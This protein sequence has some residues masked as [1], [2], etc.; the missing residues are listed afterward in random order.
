[1]KINWS[2]VILGALLMALGFLYIK[3]CKNSASYLKV[4]QDSLNIHK[5]I[6]QKVIDDTLKLKKA[7]DSL[8]E[9]NILDNNRYTKKIDSLSKII[10]KTNERFQIT[11]D[12]IG[13]L[14][15]QL[16]TFYLNNDTDALKNTY[17]ELKQKLDEANNQLF[18]L[19]ND[20][21][22]VDFEKDS[23]ILRQR[24]VIETLKSQLDSA[25]KLLG[26]QISN[27]KAEEA[28]IQ[29]LIDKNK[30]ARFIKLLETIGAGIAGLFIGKHL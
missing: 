19:Q 28:Q 22:G 9:K 6:T 25:F 30:K 3:Q 5:E 12:S 16:K 15:G 21:D 1:M 14:Y 8:M 7:N 20:R 11:K 18:I 13:Y 24:G 2:S 17:I 27:S 26:T 10:R 4:V 29:K 23:E